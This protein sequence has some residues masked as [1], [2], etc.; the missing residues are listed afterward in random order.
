MSVCPCLPSFS[1]SL[2]LYSESRLVTDVRSPG[3]F[4][5]SESVTSFLGLSHKEAG[6]TPPERRT[7]WAQNASDTR[8][9]KLGLE[10]S[11]GAQQ[12]DG[13]TC[14]SPEGSCG[15]AGNVSCITYHGTRGTRRTA[16]DTA[17]CGP[18]TSGG[19]GSHPPQ[20]PLCSCLP[21]RHP[22]A[23]PLLSQGGGEWYSGE[24]RPAFQPFSANSCEGHVTSATV[25][26]SKTRGLSPQLQEPA[27]RWEK[28]KHGFRTDL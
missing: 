10:A 19:T 18:G 25:T 28:L 22:A 2:L 24:L 1:P 6:Q 26:G 27:A 5:S 3:T 21:A 7:E 15:R 9:E 20:C 11:R 23:A 13:R 12:T 16:G 4:S 8:P 14:R 17:T